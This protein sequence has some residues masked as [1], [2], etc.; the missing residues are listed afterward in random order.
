MIKPIISIIIPTRNE[1]QNIESCVNSIVDSKISKSTYEIL[2]IDNYSKD[3]TKQRIKQL[4]KKSKKGLIRFYVKGKE[5]SA[6]RN[7]GAKKSKGKYLLFLDADMTIST[8]LL[9]ECL[10]NITNRDQAKRKTKKMVGLYVPEIIEGNSFWTKVR[11]FERGFYNATVIDAV[12]FINKDFFHKVNG[13]DEKLNAFEDWDLN[14]R[15]KKLGDFHI[16]D[17]PLFHNEQQ[18]NLQKFI[19]KKNRYVLDYQK[20]RKKWINNKDVDKQ[21]SFA[22]R[23]F[24][25][26]VENKKWLKLIRHPFLYLF[27]LCLKFLQGVNFLKK[28]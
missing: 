23:Y 3:Q 25:V 17:T 4:I 16:V 14:L 15:L 7:F 5:R 20:Y 6:Q 24:F 21:F 8:N 9:K 22:Y 10:K 1:D 11:R 19:I 27:I 28:K 12:R 2:V 13:F 26:F 18:F